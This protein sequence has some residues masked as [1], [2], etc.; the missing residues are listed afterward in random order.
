ME[1]EGKAWWRRNLQD[2]VALLSGLSPPLDDLGKQAGQLHTRPG[3]QPT[4]RSQLFHEALYYRRT[5]ID[6]MAC[7]G[8]ACT[9]A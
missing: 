6:R 4:P 7:T 1:G 8:A 2:V 9:E 3:Q 5:P